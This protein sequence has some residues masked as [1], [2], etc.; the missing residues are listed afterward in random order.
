MKTAAVDNS[1][2]DEFEAKYR[3]WQQIPFVMSPGA[4]VRAFRKKKQ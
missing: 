2:E 1:K 4:T 3:D